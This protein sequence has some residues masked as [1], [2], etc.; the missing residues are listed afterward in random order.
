MHRLPHAILIATTLLAAQLIAGSAHTATYDLEIGET[1][2]NFTGTERTAFSINGAVPGP[3][4]RFRQGEEVTLN[5]T[6][7]LDESASI[8]WHGLLLP[9]EMD[10]VPGISFDGIAPGATFTYRFTL[11]QAGTYWYH[12][13]SGYQEQRGVYGP[14]IVDPAGR[15]RITADRDYVVLLSDWLDEDPASVHANLKVSSD[16]Y[17]YAQRTVFDFFG[18]VAQKG[19]SATLQDRKIPSSSTANPALIP[20]ARSSSLASGCACASSMA[21]R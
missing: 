5:V 20:G 19:L 15:D 12:S 21:R 7:T 13:H 18:D 4:L 10:G 9:P 8:H 3:L 6:N 1:T 11:R 16:Y 14:M 2:V 17:N